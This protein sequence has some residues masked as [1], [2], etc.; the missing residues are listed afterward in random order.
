MAAYWKRKYSQKKAEEPGYIL[1]N[2]DSLEAV[3]KIYRQRMG[4]EALFKDCKTGGY[5][6]E[7]T[8]VSRK[9][10]ESLMLLM[11]IAYTWSG[12]KGQQIKAMGQQKYI[13]HLKEIERIQRCHSN[14]WMGS[15]G[16]L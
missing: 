8:K 16:C 15:Y 1:T 4:I 3:I 14:F 5:N 10:L 12:L 2:L 11:A 7:S 9:R 13:C 6:L